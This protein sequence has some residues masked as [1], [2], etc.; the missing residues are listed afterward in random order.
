MSP[1]EKPS[2]PKPYYEAHV[3]C[4]TNR[5]QAGHPRGS[6]ADRGSEALRDYM[7]GRARQLGI[8]NVRVN[9][10]GCLDRCE[11]GP[12]VV[13]YPEGVWYS[14]PT[15]EDI[16]E[17]LQKHLIEGGRVERLMLQ[18]ADKMPEDRAK[19]GEGLEAAE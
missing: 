15:K 16:D 11:L 12:T 8:E 14:C 10:A 18:T 7:K 5:R 4:C 13:I 2:D 6:C 17:V 9:N 1:R 19:R 3:F